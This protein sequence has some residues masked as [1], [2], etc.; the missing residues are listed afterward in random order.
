MVSGCASTHAGHAS[1]T[2][3]R[4]IHTYDG[5]WFVQHNALRSPGAASV[6]D[7]RARQRKVEYYQA[8][9]APMRR[10]VVP[11]PVYIDETNVEELRDFDFVF[12]CM[13]GRPGQEGVV[14]KLE[15]LDLPFIDT[16]LGIEDSEDG[17]RGILRVTTSTPGHCDHVWDT[18]RIPF[19]SGEVKDLYASNIQLAELNALTTAQRRHE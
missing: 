16:G 2:P 18:C 8:T 3:V 12:L 15:E 7:L 1:K 9:Y 5:D 6:E 13:D 10:G 17:L 4:E 11:H 14:R 19:A